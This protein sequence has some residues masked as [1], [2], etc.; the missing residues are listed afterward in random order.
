MTKYH[1]LLAIFSRPGPGGPNVIIAPRIIVIKN[2]VVMNKK[3][4]KKA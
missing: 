4:T 2:I 1:R 3:A